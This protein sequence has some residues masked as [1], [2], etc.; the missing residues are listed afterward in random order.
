M[1]SNILIVL[2]SLI[3]YFNYGQDS[4]CI[5]LL[6]ELQ[7]KYEGECKKG[8]AHGIG[9]AEGQDIYD[10]S[11]KKGWPNGKG[12]YTWRNGKQYVGEFNRGKMDGKGILN[13]IVQGKE[14]ILE[15]YWRQNEY[16]GKENL[17]AYQITDR[18]SLENVKLSRTNE[19]GNTIRIRMLRD[20]SLNTSVSD[21]FISND[22]GSIRDTN[23]EIYIDEAKFP[24][25]IMVKFSAQSRLNTV[26]LSCRTTFIINY[27]GDWL[28][29]LD[30]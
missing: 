18:Q 27:P 2:F 7:G 19:R 23:G 20:G 14:R 16:I 29:R 30:H 28:V 1:K 6:E 10:G 4:G 21:V 3:S 22:S 26:R 13:D 25:E 15:G 11:F 17:P 8:K 9:R 24:I 12:T 5:V